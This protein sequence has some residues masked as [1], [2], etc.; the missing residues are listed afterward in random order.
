[1]SDFET[2]EMAGALHNFLLANLATSLTE[3]RRNVEFLSLSTTRCET[4][5]E[6][7]HDFS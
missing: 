4:V 7:N 2:P 6:F 5:L 3:Q 1:M